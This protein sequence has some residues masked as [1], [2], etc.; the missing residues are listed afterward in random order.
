[1][2]RAG[3][4]PGRGDRPAR[5]RREGELGS[6]GRTLPAG[7]VSGHPRPVPRRPGRGADERCGAPDAGH[8]G[9]LDG[10]HRVLQRAVPGNGPRPLLLDGRRPRRARR[11][12]RPGCGRLP[13]P[14]RGG[15]GARVPGRHLR[16]PLWRGGLHRLVPRQL[17]GRGARGRDQDPE[18]VGPLRHDRQ[19]L[20][21]VLGPLRS[22]RP[23]AVPR[24]PGRRLAGPPPSLPGVVPPQEPSDL[25]HRRSG[26][27]LARSR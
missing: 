22:R 17:R 6:R 4:H 2:D 26:V 15:V 19:R 8:R 18:S 25:P 10:R 12:V 21:V 23:R 24:V 16:R 27:P 13:S 11:R 3:R 9:L 7:A 5:R 20:G 14:V 1:M